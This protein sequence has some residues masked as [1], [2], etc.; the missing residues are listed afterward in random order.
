MLHAIISGEVPFKN[1]GLLNQWRQRK[2]SVVQESP[3]R[4]APGSLTADRSQCLR[5]YNRFVEAAKL[6]IEQQPEAFEE[7]E[8]ASG[9]AIPNVTLVPTMPKLAVL[10]MRHQWLHR[11]RGGGGG[12]VSP[13]ARRLAV[14]A[15]GA[16]QGGAVAG[17][18]GRPVRRPALALAALAEGV[19]IYSV[20]LDRL[21]NGGRLDGRE[22]AAS[23]PGTDA[24]FRLW[25]VPAPPAAVARASHERRLKR[26]AG[27]AHARRS[28]VPSERH[29]LR[30]MR[31][32]GAR[33]PGT[34]AQLQ[35]ERPPAPRR[36]RAVFPGG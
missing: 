12:K 8:A 17:S 14:R 28:D 1:V 5:A 26:R 20:G 9:A 10:D 21:D 4:F 11:G 34:S 36:G 18:A 35:R 13:Q 29:P 7:A 33:P 16:R 24:G 2:P 6:P 32:D 15:G 19:V 31:V 27:Q 30:S 25:D 23:T 22:M 3:Y